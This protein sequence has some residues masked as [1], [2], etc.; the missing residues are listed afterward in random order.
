MVPGQGQKW[1]C[2]GDMEGP[3]WSAWPILKPGQCHSQS[4]GRSLKIVGEEIGSGGQSPHIC[5][6]ASGVGSLLMLCPQTF[7]KSLV[8]PK[9]TF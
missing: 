3:P 8:T 5:V 1:D 2:D 6:E 7:H 9:V 4:L